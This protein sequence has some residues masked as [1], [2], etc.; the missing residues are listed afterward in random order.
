MDH[1]SRS[2]LADPHLA[3]ELLLRACELHGYAP[4]RGVNYFDGTL[5]EP[6][7]SIEGVAAYAVATER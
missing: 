6:G 4:G 1:P 7:F 2:K 3:R 5:F